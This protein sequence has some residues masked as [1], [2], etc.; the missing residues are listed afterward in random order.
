MMLDW[1]YS[2]HWSLWLILLLSILLLMSYFLRN[3]DRRSDLLTVPAGTVTRSEI[4][5]DTSAPPTFPD[6][7]DIASEPI[8][9]SITESIT[10]PPLDIS[11]TIMEPSRNLPQPVFQDTPRQ[12]ERIQPGSSR[13][14]ELCRQIISEI[15]RK[16]FVKVRPDFLRNPETGCNLELDCYNQELKIALEYNGAQHYMWPNFTGQSHAEFVEQVRRDMF[17]QKRCEEE[18]IYLIIVPY[19]I[20][21]HLIRQYIDFYRLENVAKRQQ[22]NADNNEMNQF[23]TQNDGI[24]ESYR[25]SAEQCQLSV[26][27]SSETTQSNNW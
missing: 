13:K 12:R 18:G 16:P 11:P 23:N 4:A 15:Y 3:A 19:T 6:P 1:L 7:A 9:Q 10:E 8:P 26:M 14:E 17:K 21:E 25:Q 20:P 2:Q 24:L 5:T 22:M 27:E